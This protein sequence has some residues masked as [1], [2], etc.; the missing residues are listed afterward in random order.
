MAGTSKRAGKNGQSA[1][2]DTGSGVPE[3]QAVVIIHGMGEQRPM[4]TLRSF[5]RAVWQSDKDIKDVPNAPIGPEK[6]RERSMKQPGLAEPTDV[7]DAEFFPSYHGQS[8]QDFRSKRAW[9]APDTRTGLHELHRI[10]TGVTE[11]DYRVD[12]YELYWAD[13]MQGTSWNHLKSWLTGLLLRWPHQVPRDV[14]SLW[15]LLW[16]STLVLF[17]VGLTAAPSLAALFGVGDMFKS[18]SLLP[19]SV[20]VLLDKPLCTWI[21][22]RGQSGFFLLVLAGAALWVLSRVRRIDSAA[23]SGKIWSTGWIRVSKVTALLLAAAFCWLASRYFHLL[24]ELS[25][26][27][28]I[29]AL[30]TGVVLVIN[31]FVLPYFGD[32]ARYVKASPENVAKRGQVR[33]RGMKLLRALH[34][35]DPNGKPL[36]VKK[37]TYRRVVLV[38]HSLGSIVAYDLLL[39]FWAENGPLGEP[40]AGDLKATVSDLE[41]YLAREN[42]GEAFDLETFRNLQYRVMKAMLHKGER[43]K[44]TDLATIGSPLTHAE[45]LVT[46]DKSRFE[47]LVHQ[48][49]LSK[50]PPYPYED[51]KETVTYLAKQDNG[52]STRMIHHA[53]PFAAVRWTNIYDKRSFVLGG[54]LVSGPVQENFGE[55]VAD[56]RVSIRRRLAGL[57]TRIFTHTLYW[58]V[59]SKGCEVEPGRDVPDYKDGDLTHIGLVREAVRLNSYKDFYPDSA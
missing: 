52:T 57:W 4:D 32:V 7:P 6:A 38:G 18:V 39:Q 43:F 30:A 37:P 42:A 35:L 16:F 27:T 41:S 28:V 12:F 51:G 34:D 25:L 31:S 22:E 1:G 5:V 44:I 47:E 29:A 17:L 53:A 54:D 36:D 9:M 20:S 59:S 24:F 2:K 58:D 14:M 45:F 15:C 26:K 49:L 11:D 56:R 8:D 3:K 21:G 48:R 13:I 46:H 19:A 23:K 50:A 55:G 33:D 10:T 40:L